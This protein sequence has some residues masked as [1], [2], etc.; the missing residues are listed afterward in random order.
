MELLTDQP[1][2]WHPSLRVAALDAALIKM[3]SHAIDSVG[4]FHDVVMNDC[5]EYGVSVDVICIRSLLH[6]KV[7][8]QLSSRRTIQ[9]SRAPSARTTG[10]TMFRRFCSRA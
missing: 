7:V 9:C 4:Q 8:P 5:G 1:V 2:Q 6:T 10:V 3:C